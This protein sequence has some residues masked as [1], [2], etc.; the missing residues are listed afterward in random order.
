MATNC[1]ASWSSASNYGALTVNQ[2]LKLGEYPGLGSPVVDH[3]DDVVVRCQASRLECIAKAEQER[4]VVLVR[5][6]LYPPNDN[7]LVSLDRQ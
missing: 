6:V 1:F 5:R 3:G 4:Q 7:V 2:N